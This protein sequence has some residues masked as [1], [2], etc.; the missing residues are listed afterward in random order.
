MCGYPWLG[1][2]LGPGYLA[3][4]APGDVL[5]RVLAAIRATAGAHGRLQSAPLGRRCRG[6]G[7]S[8]IALTDCGLKGWPRSFT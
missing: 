7:P 8:M 1:D 3:A 2:N 4:W 6:C 5:R